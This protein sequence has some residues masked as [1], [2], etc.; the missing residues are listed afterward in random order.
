M[1]ANSVALEIQFLLVAEG[2]SAEL[3]FSK[4]SSSQIP[5]HQAPGKLPPPLV[6]LYFLNQIADRIPFLLADR[7]G[8][9]HTKRFAQ[10]TELYRKMS[11]LCASPSPPPIP[12]TCT[13]RL[14][15]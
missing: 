13:R 15:R 1:E 14:P 10:L 5:F 3:H 2:Q 8:L 4:F 9:N 11:D 6:L 7:F 12:A